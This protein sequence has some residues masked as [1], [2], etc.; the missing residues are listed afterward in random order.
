MPYHLSRIR[1]IQFEVRIFF[2]YFRNVEFLFQILQR[3]RVIFHVAKRYHKISF[4]KRA[5]EIYIPV[6]VAYAVAFASS[7]LIYFLHVPSCALA[8]ITRTMNGVNVTL[9]LRGLRVYHLRV[10]E[11]WQMKYPRVLY[12]LSLKKVRSQKRLRVFKWALGKLTLVHVVRK[13]QW[14]LDKALVKL[15]S[16]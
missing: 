10:H 11:C 2:N 12:R 8:S 7:K 1:Q 4:C 5:W 9:L 13:E 16:S 15:I 6:V 14:F 3:E